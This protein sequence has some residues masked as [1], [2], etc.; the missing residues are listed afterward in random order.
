MSQI[1]TV[2]MKLT[3][4]QHHLKAKLKKFADRVKLTDKEM[5]DV[6]NIERLMAQRVAW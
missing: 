4:E 6:A 3:E 1:D 2:N 5:E